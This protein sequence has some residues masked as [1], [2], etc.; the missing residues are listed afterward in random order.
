VAATAI[1]RT[2]IALVMIFAFAEL[3]NGACCAL[4]K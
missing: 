3:V 2:T 1:P 4:Q